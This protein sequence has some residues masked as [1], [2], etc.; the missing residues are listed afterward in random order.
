MPPKVSVIT[1]VYNRVTW[2]RESL[3]SA[4]DQTYPEVEIV[5]IDDGSDTKEA[6]QI[7]ASYS[8]IRYHWQPNQGSGSA[9][10]KGITLCSGEFL[11]FLDD[12]DWLTQGAVAEKMDYMQQDPGI[13]IV[14]SDLLLVDGNNS[15]I[16]RYFAH[17]RQPPPSGDL[18]FELLPSNFIPPASM[19]WRRSVVEEAGGFP[20]WSGAEDWFLLIRAAERT[21]FKY[22]D[23][24]HGGYRIHDTNMTRIIG[25]Q[26]KGYTK[27]QEAVI[28]S[29]HFV[30]LPSRSQAKVFSHYAVLQMMSGDPALA[31][32]YLKRARKIAPTYLTPLVLSIA[33]TL[34]QTT[35]RSLI[36]TFRRIRY[37]LRPIPSSTS[38]FLGY[39]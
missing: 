25:Q 2:L 15:I 33:A 3:E 34:G 36:K 39:D 9:R 20:D 22:V 5:L 10:N 14:Y 7:A 1:P 12:D 17:R 27:V 13:G 18:Y 16:G 26:T 24:V 6:E 35:F 29:G 23:K 11:L 30:A 19:L 21:R 37:L 32:A 31:R 4:L 28:N 8:N 38:I